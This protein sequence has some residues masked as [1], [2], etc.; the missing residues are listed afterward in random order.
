MDEL[1]KRTIRLPKDVSELLS[2]RTKEKGYSHENAYIAHLIQADP[3]KKIHD[4]LT[5]KYESIN[6]EIKDLK[7]LITGLKTMFEQAEQD[8]ISARKYASAGF[9][10]GMLT[11]GKSTEFMQK[12]VDRI[13]AEVQLEIKGRHT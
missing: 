11:A 2:V 9:T 13:K 7:S 5:T 3:G 10:F 1:K 12:D 4:E 6:S 8:L